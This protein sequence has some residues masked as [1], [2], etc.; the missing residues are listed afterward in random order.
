MPDSVVSLV[1]GTTTRAERNW[2]SAWATAACAWSTRAWKSRGS[3]RTSTCPAFT[4]WLSF[5]STSI[6]LPAILGATALTCASTSASSED[7][8][9]R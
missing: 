3:M 7:T 6:T 1:H 2:L 5:T 8:W 4:G 9:S